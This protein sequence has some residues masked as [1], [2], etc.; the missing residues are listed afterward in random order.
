M[1][2]DYPPAPDPETEW[3]LRFTQRA[4][5][6]LRV[7]HLEPSS[8]DQ[9][10]A[11]TPWPGIVREFRQQ[12]SLSLEATQ[13]YLS[14]RGLP[15][16]AAL[17]GP[18]S[19]RA[20]TWFDP[21]TSVCWF[22]GFTPSHEYRL[23]E[24]RAACDELLPTEEDEVLLE[25]F[26][27]ELDFDTRV[28]PGVLHLVSQALR[29][30]ETPCR[31]TVGQLLRLEIAAVVVPVDVDSGLSDVYLS[32]TYPLPHPTSVPDWPGAELLARV[33]N[34]VSNGTS[35]VCYTDRVPIGDGQWRKVD[36]AREWAVIVPSVEVRF[37]SDD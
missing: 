20:C 29:S 14:M 15:G 23:L 16:I 34:I 9:I 3:E 28:R 27:E 32:V 4:L 6:D 11:R 2:G 10:E 21:D 19:G 30:P 35:I 5:E 18:G 22:L 24:A 17:H 8:L 36:P 13:G 12:R 31:G 37:S 26:R 7:R 25:V 1:T 33:G